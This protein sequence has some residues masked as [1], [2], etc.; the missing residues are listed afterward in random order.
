MRNPLMY[1]MT[2]ES[3]G[4]E[5]VFNCIIYLFDREE[6]PTEFIKLMATYGLSCLDEIGL[7]TNKD[8]CDSLLYFTSSWIRDFAKEKHIP[9][10]SRYL[11]GEEVNLLEIRKCLN[12]GGCVDL[13]TYRDGVHYVTI[14]NMDSEFMYIFDP[15]FQPHKS[16]SGQAGI[17]II[18]NP[19]LPYNRRVKIEN[20]IL[21]IKSELCLGEV[22][23]REAVFIYRNNAILQREF[24]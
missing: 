22:D 21:E 10:K 23:D 17:D 1:Q 15:Y 14:V 16:K 8:F 12:A 7:P 4:V 9:L 3:C 2:E 11:Q 6:M 19:N 20:F 18:N 5:A 24:V 13:K